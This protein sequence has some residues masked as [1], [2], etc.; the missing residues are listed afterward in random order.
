MVE[1]SSNDALISSSVEAGAPARLGDISLVGSSGPRQLSRAPDG[2]F[3]IKRFT[4][5]VASGETTGRRFVAVVNW[6][7]ELKRLVPVN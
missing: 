6:P 3:L 7:E 1:V 5:L 4:D 2:R